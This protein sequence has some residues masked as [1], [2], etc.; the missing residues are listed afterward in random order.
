MSDIPENR[1]P[2]D[3]RLIEPDYPAQALI[4]F[5]LTGWG[6]GYARFEMDLA[7][8]HMNRHGNPHGGIL[9]A[10]LDSAMGFTGAYTGDPDDIC[11]TM[12]LTITV[13]Y[14]APP[15]GPRLVAEGVSTGGG[16]KIYFTDGKL[17]DGRG[18]LCATATGTF[19]RR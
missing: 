2:I 6:E 7:D 13:N 19:K 15:A 5:E 17:W 12:S 9:A 1:Y 4:G 18:R 8:H 14:L 16:R 10:I 11:H 3:P